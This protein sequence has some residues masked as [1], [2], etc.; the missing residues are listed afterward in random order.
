VPT[1]GRE[2]NVSLIGSA[3]VS[4]PS[5]IRRPWGAAILSLLAPGLGHLYAGHPGRGALVWAA[6]H[7]VVVSGFMVAIVVPPSALL[8]VAVVCVFL[9]VP[10]LVAWDAIRMVRRGAGDYH[11][12]WYNRWYV[13]VGIVL[14]VG[15]LWPPMLVGWLQAHVAQAY[16]LP[17]RSMEPTLLAGD[18]ILSKPLR[19]EVH[20]GQIVVHGTPAGILVKRV[21]G[22]PG[23]TIGMRAG[24]LSFG[25]RPYPEPYARR[26]TADPIVP[27]F[28]WQ[29]AYLPSGVNPATYRPSLQTWGPLV[30]PRGQYFLLGDNRNESLDSRFLGFVPRDSISAEATV[31]YL[32]RDPG[33]STIRWQR[34]GRSV[35]R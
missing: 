27:E 8:L 22:L 17:S 34:I 25:G 18:Y 2:L 16:K 14:L 1:G 32:S 10:I 35:G 24:Q 5:A 7:V 23:D 28:A 12:S 26:D 21:V 31:V 3:D 13:Y 20:R 19:G 29:R 15:F 4:R 9:A 6:T 33:S 11:L 30:V